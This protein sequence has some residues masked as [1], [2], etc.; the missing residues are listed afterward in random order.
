MDPLSIT[1]GVLAILTAAGA[2]TKKVRDL[3]NAPRELKLVLQEANWVQHSLRS[4]LEIIEQAEAEWSRPGGD[5]HLEA[6]SK[7]FD[8]AQTALNQLQD[9]ITASIR[10]L[11][12]SALVEKSDPSRDTATENAFKV[13]FLAYSRNRAKI[14]EAKEELQGARTQIVLCLGSL[15]VFVS[16]SRGVSSW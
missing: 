9:L 4:V 12:P 14:K 13:D 15:N 2:I 7:A 3:Q 10:P 6:L 5:M 1:T 16:S 11:A 8:A